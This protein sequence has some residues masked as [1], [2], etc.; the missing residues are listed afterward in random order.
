MKELKAEIRLSRV[1]SNTESDFI[2]LSIT[3]KD[4]HLPVVKARIPLEQ[5]ADLLTNRSVEGILELNQSEDLGKVRQVQIISVPLPED[6]DV[7]VSRERFQS[8]METMTRPFEI[9]D[10]KAKIP[11]RYN[12]RDRLGDYYSVTFVR[13][14]ESKDLDAPQDEV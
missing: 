1:S 7:F 13:Y 3:D 9:L 14:V 8:M 12:S 11:E 6:F 10:W 5:F 4:S 2:E